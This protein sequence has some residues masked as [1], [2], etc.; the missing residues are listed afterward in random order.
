MLYLDLPVIPSP[1]LMYRWPDYLVLKNKP[2]VGLL[3]FDIIIDKIGLNI[4][5][6]W[7]FFIDP[8]FEF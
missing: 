2:M 3:D 6:L 8:V 5:Y 4:Y 7:L 1:G